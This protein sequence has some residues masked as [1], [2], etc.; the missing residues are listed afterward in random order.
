MKLG[1]QSLIKLMRN[2]EGLSVLEI[3]QPEGIAEGSLDVTIPTNAI[4]EKSLNR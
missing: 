1:S 3:L 4:K 2:L